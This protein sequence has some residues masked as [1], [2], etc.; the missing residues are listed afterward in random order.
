[1]TEKVSTLTWNAIQ[2]FEEYKQQ[3]LRKPPFEIF[4]S[5]HGINARQ[6]I[7][8]YLIECAENDFEADDIKILEGFGND[9]I[10]LLFLTYLEYDDTSVQSYNDIREIVERFLED[11]KNEI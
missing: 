11:H 9:L 3:M 1:M 6:E 2:G 5:A 4:E 7:S 8:S 10:E